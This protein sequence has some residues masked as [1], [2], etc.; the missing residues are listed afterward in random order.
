MQVPNIE[1]MFKGLPDYQVLETAQ[2][3]RILQRGAAADGLVSQELRALFLA[4]HPIPGRQLLEGT[5]AKDGSGA[6]MLTEE[7]RIF[8]KLE[9][10]LYPETADGCFVAGTPVWTDKGLVPI[11]HLK[12]GD[13]VLS[14]P[15]AGGEDAYKRVTKTFVFEEKPIWRLEYCTETADPMYS[16]YLT[17]NHP[18]WVSDQGW[19]NAEKLEHGD[20]MQFNDGVSAYVMSIT[21]VRSGPIR[22]IGWWN[23]PFH[24]DDVHGQVD[25]RYGDFRDPIPESDV[26]SYTDPLH[27]KVF[28]IEVDD[29]DTYFVGNK[30][31]WVH[32]T[33]L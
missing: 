7:A 20:M 11:E 9:D 26:R 18:L 23:D 17:P 13:W 16:L 27:W 28:D 14:K 1:T 33:R 2:R 25:F 29:H 12:V 5:L 8:W 30:G 31:L 15:E 4:W 24:G 19:T 32:S 3:L 10:R 21:K 6:P 22:G